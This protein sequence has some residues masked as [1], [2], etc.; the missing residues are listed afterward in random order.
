MPFITTGALPPA[1]PPF[2][3]S[4]GIYIPVIAKAE[5]VDGIL[6]QL[7]VIFVTANVERLRPLFDWSLPASM[8]GT[9]K[10]LLQMVRMIFRARWEI[11]EPR[12]QEAKYRAPSAER[13]AEIARSVIADYDQMQREAEKEGMS[14]LDSFYATFHRELKPELE[15][16]GE[17]WVQLQ[18]RCARHRPTNPTSSAVN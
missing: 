17:E 4:T 5:S 14:G 2:R 12:Y 9:F 18:N 6:R 1:L 10:A 16:C 15:A 8:P 7:A 11:L 3:T 13:C